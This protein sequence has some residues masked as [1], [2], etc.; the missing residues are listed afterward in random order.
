[1]ALLESVINLLSSI[2]SDKIAVHDERCV[3]MRNRNA[4]CLRCVAAC[5]TGALAQ[6]GGELI[7]RPERCIGC[8]TCAAACPTS[9][10]EV[11][12]PTDAELTDALKR[13]L[14]VTGGHP[15]VACERAVDACRARLARGAS[16]A[17]WRGALGLTAKDA[18]V[19]DEDAIVEVPCL[20]RVDE[21]L[22]AAMAA[23]GGADGTLV[24]HGCEG[25]DRETGGVQ[26]FDVMESA[27][28]L[29]A[30]FGRDFTVEM[31][32]EMPERAIVAPGDTYR[33][34][35]EAA[36]E[37][38]GAEA[39]PA[40]TAPERNAPADPERRAL[41]SQAKDTA[42][43]LAGDAVLDTLGLSAEP[44]P[45]PVKPRYRKVN[46]DGTLSRFVPTR[47]TLLYNYLNRLGEPA[48]DEVTNRVIGHIDIDTEACS[49]CRMCAVFCPTGALDRAEDGDFWGLVHRPAACVQCRSCESLCPAHAIT[50]SDTVPMDQF[51]G[52]EAVLYAMEKPRWE[53]N[54]PDSMYNKVHSIIGEDLE[55]CMF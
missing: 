42:A 24:C 20:G 53:A 9:A 39:A 35:R 6:E 31:V 7:V 41:F 50:V 55:M 44:A 37:S 1:M 38:A 5:T 27:E 4:Q 29:M 46:A 49:S 19:L 14:V 17:G 30:A 11:R 3:V 18:P 40:T 21:S 13:S 48:D 33:A 28:N 52:R 8:G 22:I 47:R 16:L 10:I 45:E 15:I 26:A 2:E 25:C 36:A 54:K 34:R 51:M 43:S 12:T 23:F 32:E